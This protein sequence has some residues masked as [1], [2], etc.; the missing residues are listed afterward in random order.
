MQSPGREVRALTAL[1]ALTADDGDAE[2]LVQR[3]LAE[4]LTDWPDFGGFPRGIPQ[5]LR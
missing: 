4:G 5:A 3:A 1:T 2:R